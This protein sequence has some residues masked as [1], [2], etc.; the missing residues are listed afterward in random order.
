MRDLD[1]FSGLWHSKK[2]PNGPHTPELWDSRAEEWIA[3]LRVQQSERPKAV[4]EYL[5]KR[6][7]LTSD[8]AI[9]DVGCGPGLFV[10]EFSRRCKRA[11]GVDFS[12]K[13][14]EFAQQNCEKQGLA[15]AEFIQSD[16]NEFSP[17]EK[18]D[19]VFASNSPAVSNPEGISK[20][21]SLSNGWCCNVTFVKA[22]GRTGIGFYSLLNIL[23]LRGFYPETYYFTVNDSVYGSI[24]W[25][26][27]RQD[28][29]RK[30]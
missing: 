27:N 13:F 1:Y 30:L 16:F 10:E 20:F 25:N 9:L 2:S 6:G 14:I 15:N 11:V 21:E 19:I 26:I 7:V 24:L 3:D 22:E 29:E 18:F 8:S 17:E 28:K 12:Q 5:F 23:Y 4:A